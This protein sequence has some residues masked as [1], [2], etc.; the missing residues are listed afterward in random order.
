MNS[1]A[2]YWISSTVLETRLKILEIL[3]I[4]GLPVEQFF[5]TLAD[6]SIFDKIKKIEKRK[7]DNKLNVER[8]F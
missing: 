8:S 6:T 4:M 3:I 2:L 5:N 1:L 7:K